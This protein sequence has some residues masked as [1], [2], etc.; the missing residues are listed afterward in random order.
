MIL[1]AQNYTCL[2][3][4]ILVEYLLEKFYIMQ[5]QSLSYF[6]AAVT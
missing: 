2:N 3:I 6:S 4:I 5:K 1:N